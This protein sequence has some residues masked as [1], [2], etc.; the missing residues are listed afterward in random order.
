[1]QNVTKSLTNTKGLSSSKRR[2]PN[3]GPGTRALAEKVRAGLEPLCVKIEIAGSIRRFRPEVHDVDL[4]AIPKNLSEAGPLGGTVQ[5]SDSVV[6]KERFPKFLK[7]QGLP[8]DICGQELIR[9]IFQIMVFRWIFT[10]RDV[11]PGE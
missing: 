11:R 10:G 4:V 5:I 8:V 2:S 9:C 1:M 7:K 3:A 6:W